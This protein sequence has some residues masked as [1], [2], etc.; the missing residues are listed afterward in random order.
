MPLI[1]VTRIG[2]YEIIAPLGA[3][4][5]RE[6]Y[7]PRDMV[8]T[9][10][11]IAA[12]LIALVTLSAGE[13]SAKLPVPSLRL[14]LGFGVDTT[15]SPAREVFDLWRRY[16]TES[17]DSVRAGLWSQAERATWQPFDLV[18]PYVYQGFSD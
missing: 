6:S 1:P 18:G 4:G 16:L 14:A 5:M 11:Q 13:P 15:G 17:S 12:L 10:Q 8:R 3:G 9:A 2:P 7:R